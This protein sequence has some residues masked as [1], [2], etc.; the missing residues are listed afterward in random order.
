MAGF[1]G[2]HLERYD[3]VTDECVD[4]IIPTDSLGVPD[5]GSIQ[6]LTATGAFAGDVN[7]LTCYIPSV[8]GGAGDMLQAVYDPDLVI[9]QL[10]GLGATQTMAEKT[11]DNTNLWDQGEVRIPA[12]N[13][14]S[15]TSEGQMALDIDDS[16]LRIFDG[17]SVVSF[18]GDGRPAE[19]YLR[20][21]ELD[22]LPTVDNQEQ[23][24]ILLTQHSGGSGVMVLT[25]WWLPGSY[26]WVVMRERYRV[27]LATYGPLTVGESDVQLNGHVIPR[28]SYIWEG[29]LVF[30]HDDGAG[31]TSSAITMEVFNLGTGT[32]HVTCTLPAATAQGTSV[33]FTILEQTIPAGA[34]LKS[35]LTAVDSTDEHYTISGYIEMGMKAI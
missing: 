8:G 20:A 19:L 6:Y 4:V 29:E 21:S 13:A 11:F 15:V 30:A 7:D 26:V 3:P 2:V 32:V 27:N 34:V 33:A 24:A 9:E 16:I 1:C 35:R 28:E 22:P 23:I 10:A 18:W 14:P 25:H 5:Y 12:S 17:T 31:P